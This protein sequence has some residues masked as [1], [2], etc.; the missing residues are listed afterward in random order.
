MAFALWKYPVHWLAYGLG[1]GLVP[2]MPGTFGSL[3][4]I[5]IY[6]FLS[7]SSR[8][9]YA[10]VVTVLALAGVF[11]CAQTA[12]DLGA[13]DPGVIVWDEIVGMLVAV[14]LLP[15]DWRW[16]STGFVLFRLFDVWKPYPIAAAEDAFGIGMSIMAD[17][18][19]AAIYALAILQL[20]RLGWRRYCSAD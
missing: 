16:I 6:W 9:I 7:R 17:D 13:T 1:A 15:R 2:F 18:I 8:A 14:Y 10:G 20:V 12:R 4:G 11:I 19:V 5:G 3:V